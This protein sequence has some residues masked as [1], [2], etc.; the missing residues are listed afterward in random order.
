MWVAPRAQMMMSAIWSTMPPPKKTTPKRL[1]KKLRKVCKQRGNCDEDYFAQGPVMIITSRW[2][3]GVWMPKGCVGTTL[4][5]YGGD[6]SNIYSG[7]LEVW[8]SNNWQV[9]CFQQECICLHQQCWQV[10]ISV[11]HISC[12]PTSCL[13]YDNET[14]HCVKLCSFGILNLKCLLLYSDA[15]Q[16]S[17]HSKNKKVCLSHKKSA[18]KVRKSWHQN[19]ARELRKSIKSLKMHHS[20]AKCQKIW[21]QEHVNQ[22]FWAFLQDFSTLYDLYL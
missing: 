21:N 13:S 14:H 12:F 15:I 7:G 17:I 22:R 3:L 8:G 2:E 20:K 5:E 11:C 16:S 10:N 9:Q 19:V 4:F 6:S 1:S 18:E